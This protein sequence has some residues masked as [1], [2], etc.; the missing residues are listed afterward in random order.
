M[1]ASPEQQHTGMP[2]LLAWLWGLVLLACLLGLGWLMRDG[3]PVD[4]RLTAMLPENHQSPLIERASGRL[5]RSFEDRFVLLLSSPDLEADAGALAQALSDAGDDGTPLLAELEWQPRDLAKNDPRQAL[6]AYRYRLLTAELRQ[7]IDQHGG[8]TLIQPALRALFS[9]AGQPQPV[10]DPFGLLER[11]ID[12]RDDSPIRARDGL[13]TVS[14]ESRTYALLIGHLAGS[15]YDL[16]AQQ[17]LSG[18]LEAF[19]RHHPEATLLRSGLILHAAAAA[20]Q[21]RQE[22]T[23]IGLGALIGLVAILLVVFRSP[24]ALL[25]MLLPLACG[26]LFALPLTLMLFGRLHLMTLAFGASL[27]GIAIDYALHLQ[28]DRAVHGSAFRLR[29][30]LP[31]LA[32]GLVS[33]LLAYLAQTLTPLPGLRQM[34]TFASFGLLGAWLSVVLWLPRMRLPHHA[35]TARLAERLWRHT[36]PRRRLSPGTALAATLLAGVLIGWQLT[37]DDSLRLLNPS[38]PGLLDQERQVQRLLGSDTGNRYLL[39]T[40]TNEAAL[41]KRLAEL[42][43]TL[44]EWIAEGA[45]LDYINLADSVP[46]PSVQQENLARVRRLYGDPLDRLVN[47]AGLEARVAERARQRLDRSPALDVTTWLD[48]PLGNAQRRLW[49]GEVASGNEGAESAVAATLPV[50]LDGR[51]TEAREALEQRLMRLAA[52][53]EG[54]TYVDRVARIAELLGRLREHIVWW[55]ATAVVGLTLLLAWRYGRDTWRV[56]T[57]PL[58]ALMG[59]LSLFAVLG[60]PLNVFSQLGLLLVLGIGLDAGIFSVEHGRRPSTWLAISLSTLTSLLAFGLLTFSATPALHYLGLSC[61]SGLTIV[62]CLVPWVRPHHDHP[63]TTQLPA[64]SPH[65]T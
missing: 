27:I 54:V 36:T 65:G 29:R 32:L 4:T 55:V 23:T 8:R 10:V 45:N 56:L 31:G 14:G 22:I 1:P 21:A 48:T 49:L 28:C 25:Q 5:S 53:D 42:G 7:A 61:L 40:A 46:P 17:T 13:L 19:E 57:P 26:L 33:S 63:S 44:E 12:A 34:A 64:E 35:V 11:W 9:P 3:L 30:L 62:W 47:Q 6:D 2:R 43:D 51:D 58:G 18:V 60:I 38:S 16:A 24:R 39:V 20:R 15:P 41:L 59:V 52:R 37:S 50:D